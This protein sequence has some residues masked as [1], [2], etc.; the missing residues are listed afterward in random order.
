MSVKVFLH[1]GDVTS[2]FSLAP[3]FFFF[4]PGNVSPLI[5]VESFQKPDTGDGKLHQNNFI[6]KAIY[7]FI[8]T[9]LFGDLWLFFVFSCELPWQANPNLIQAK[10]ELNVPVIVGKMI[11]ESKTEKLKKSQNSKTAALFYYLFQQTSNTPIW[12]ILATRSFFF[13]FTLQLV[14]QQNH[15]KIRI[16]FLYI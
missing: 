6:R 12:C 7:L 9:L 16:H 13:F 14:C 10:L 3:A 2:T 1:P 4:S 15:L 8:C 11:Q 5:Q